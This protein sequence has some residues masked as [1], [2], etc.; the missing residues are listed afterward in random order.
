MESSKAQNLDNCSLI[1]YG[2]PTLVT[3]SLPVPVIFTGNNMPPNVE[4]PNCTSAS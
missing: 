1:F 2:V 3:L 4:M